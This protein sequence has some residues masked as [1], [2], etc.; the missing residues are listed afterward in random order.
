MMIESSTNYQRVFI[1]LFKKTKPQL[2]PNL[3]R[4]SD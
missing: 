2:F 1:N 3:Y 4:K